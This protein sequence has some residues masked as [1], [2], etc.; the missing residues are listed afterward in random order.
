MDNTLGGMHGF[1]ANNPEL[2][3]QNPAIASHL[4]KDARMDMLSENDRIHNTL[5]S[6][7]EKTESWGDI[8]D[9]S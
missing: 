8:V 2:C 5:E 4:Y 1:C 7:Y 6:V 3:W 9:N